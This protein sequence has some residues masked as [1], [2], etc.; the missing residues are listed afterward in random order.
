MLYAVDFVYNLWVQLHCNTLLAKNPRGSSLWYID[1]LL[2]IL[3]WLQVF[4]LIQEMPYI[5]ITY[6]TNYLSIYQYSV[7]AHGGV[8]DLNVRFSGQLLDRSSSMVMAEKQPYTTLCSIPATSIYLRNV[9][10]C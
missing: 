10:V 4:H 8:Q 7:C 2:D 3:Y 6:R 1:P 5:R 9:Y